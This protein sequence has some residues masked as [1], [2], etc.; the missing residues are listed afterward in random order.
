MTTSVMAQTEQDVQVAND[1]F[2][3]GEREKA[4]ELYKDLS[5]NSVAAPSIYAN[6]FALLIDQ[7]KYK[8][9]EDLVD[10]MSKR[11]PN[12]LQYRLDKGMIYIKQADLPKA[13]KYLK[14]LSRTLLDEPYKIRQFCDYMAQHGLIE[15]AQQAYVAAREYHKN[16]TLFTLELANIYRLQGKKNEMVAE[17]LGYVSQTPGNVNYTKNLLQALLT[18]P[19]ELEALE[20]LLYQRIQEYPDTEL[21]ADLL[22]WTHLQQKNFYAAYIQARAYD[23]RYRKPNTRSF[24]IGQISLNNGDYENATRCFSYI[25][26]EFPNTEEVLPSR[27][28][29]IKASEGKIKRSYP[30]STD[31]V[32]QL[33]GEYQSF[34]LRYP[35]N[36][37]AFEATISRAQL[38]ATYLSQKDSAISQLQKLIN[39]PKVSLPLKSRSRLELG[40]IYLLVNQPWEATLLYAQVEK[41]QKESPLGYEAKLRNAKLSY[42]KGDFRLAQQ[43]LD[44][45]KEATS[46]EIANDAMELSMRIKENATFDTTGAALREFAQIEL[47]LYQNKTAEAYKRLVHFTEPK[48]VTIS[49]VDALERGTKTDSSIRTDSVTLDIPAFNQT[50][51]ILDDVYW[52]LA[53]LQ[54]RMGKTDDALKTLQKILDEF[55][56]DVLADDALFLTAE[57]WERQKGSSSKAMELYRT[58]LDQYPGSVFAAEARKRYR[59]LRGDFADKPN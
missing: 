46:R 5:K 48:Q 15:Y 44:I 39:N 47:L 24:E 56:Q 21:Y 45:L 40:D 41:T 16:Q 50:P 13:D 20:K 6:Y 31:S 34:I 55:G 35:D 57:I 3:R 1:Y 53:G 38:F 11:D 25:L 14:S 36:S 8:D 2:L 4:L 51:T 28:G 54:L 33:T 42:Y 12:N 30:V 32:R 49:A 37:S 59:A 9:A 23:K 18:R 7:S 22:I 43:H 10:R 58:F 27:L 52:K 17:Y 19:D 29:L 26:K